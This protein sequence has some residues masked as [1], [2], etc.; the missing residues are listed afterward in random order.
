MPTISANRKQQNDVPNPRTSPLLPKGFTFLGPPIINL[1]G[2]M[3]NA[4][5]F[6]C[7]IRDDNYFL[8]QFILQQNVGGLLKSTPTSLEELLFSPNP[9]NLTKKCTGCDPNT[10]HDARVHSYKDP[11]EVCKGTGEMSLSL[12]AVYDEI[13]EYKFSN[14]PKRKYLNL[15]KAIDSFGNEFYK[16][17]RYKLTFGC[18]QY[19]TKLSSSYD[20]GED[21]S[22]SE[23]HYQL[24]QLLL[25]LTSESHI[26]CYPRNI[27]IEGYFGMADMLL[28]DSDS[29]MFVEVLSQHAAID[30]NRIKNKLRLADHHP[31]AFVVDQYT[32]VSL[33]REHGITDIYLVD[34]QRR[35]L[36]HIDKHP[37]FKCFVCGMRKPKTS[38][39]EI[40]TVKLNT[41]I[42]VC[43]DCRR[44]IKC[45]SCKNGI[46]TI[47][48]KG[49]RGC[50]DPTKSNN[51]SVC[52]REVC[53][54]CR[55]HNESIL[56]PDEAP[57]FSEDK[58]IQWDD[59]ED[60]SPKT[61]VDIPTLLTKRFTNTLISLG[62]TTA[63]RRRAIRKAIRTLRGD[64]SLWSYSYRT[65]T[66]AH[67]VQLCRRCDRK[68][69][70]RR[71]A[72]YLQDKYT[73]RLIAK[74]ERLL[75]KPKPK[76]KPNL[77]PVDGIL[78]DEHVNP[79]KISN[80]QT[81]QILNL[82]DEAREVPH[83]PMPALQLL[84]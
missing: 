45:P 32:D 26:E 57:I 53:S 60:P 23:E 2:I 6:E 43:D 66:N 83:D 78:N 37:G 16:K 40:R 58:R 56:N 82:S 74:A 11:C 73:K 30:P 75:P 35:E 63:E 25:Q 47:R 71:H 7:P 42:L 34:Y 44:H 24:C 29:Y 22:Q 55:I 62:W 18:R 48:L 13:S 27:G 50:V 28:V 61:C 10:I 64:Y 31:M 15:D 46:L 8:E 81:S 77:V 41:A 80:L 12:V 68:I 67:Y 14:K 21:S 19:S 84:G 59:L 65:V 51:C 39:Q 38:T 69:P 3:L 9:R 33:L 54:C 72:S 4:T 76:L 36:Y 52:N 49:Q 79:T 20:D 70:K 5:P 1:N 17:F